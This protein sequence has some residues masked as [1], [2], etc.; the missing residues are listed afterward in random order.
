MIQR[1]LPEDSGARR[2]TA[3]QDRKARQET[4][5]RDIACRLR[6][7]CSHLNDEDFATL[8]D[9]IVKVQLAGEGRAR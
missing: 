9:K 3:D 4:L 2:T 6:K 7:G 5:R 8:V 1:E